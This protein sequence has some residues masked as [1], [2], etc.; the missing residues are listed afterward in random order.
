MRDFTH[1][2][3]YTVGV[4]RAY[5]PFPLLALLQGKRLASVQGYHEPGRGSLPCRPCLQGAKPGWKSYHAR[6]QWNEWRRYHLR[7]P[8]MVGSLD[9]R[10]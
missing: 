10:F 1:I 9:V 7:W 6:A 8:F 4:F 3:A 2:Q 5:S